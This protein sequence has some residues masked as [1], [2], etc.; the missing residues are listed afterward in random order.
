MTPSDRERFAGLI[1]DV[2]AF[3]GQK[4]STFGL[5][6]WWNACQ[7]FDFDAVQRALTRHAMNPERGQF[8]PKPADLVREMQGTPTDRAAR[9]WSVTLDACSRVGSYTDV[10]FDD[11][12]IHAVVEDLGGWPSLCRTD[13]DKLSYTQHRFLTAYSAYVN[14][15]DLGD[16]P[17]KLSGDRS[18]DEVYMQRGLPPPKPVLIGNTARA[19]Q[20][21]AHGSTAPRHA[22]VMLDDAMET[23]VRRIA[24]TSREDAA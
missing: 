17:V 13:A 7:G 4:V 24:A 14:R 20:V 19:L 2:L 11:P 9:A 22:L 16:Y 5:T 3:Y 8:A 10:A 6:V 18:P 1:T 12:I 23:T 15:G 21:M